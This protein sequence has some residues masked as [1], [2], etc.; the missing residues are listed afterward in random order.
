MK[1]FEEKSRLA[2][3]E[4]KHIPDNTQKLDKKKIL[5]KIDEFENKLKD[6][7]KK[8]KNKRE[9][10]I[11]DNNKIESQSIFSQVA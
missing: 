2:T 6:A 3:I 9:A 1:K 4:D 8:N 10:I 11:T 5:D 7:S